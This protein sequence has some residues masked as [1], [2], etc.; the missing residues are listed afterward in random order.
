MIPFRL[1]LAASALALIGTLTSSAQQPYQVLDHWKIGGTGGWGYLLAAPS[2]HLL[3]ITPGP[4]VEILDTKT[5]KSVGVITGVKGTHGIAL[6]ADGK[7]GYI[8][9]GGGNSVLVFDRTDFHTIATIPTG[10]N[11]ARIALEPATK[12]VWA[13]NGRSNDASVI[14]T[15]TNKVVATIKLPGKPEFPVAD[16]TGTVFVNIETANSIS[17]LDAKTHKL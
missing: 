3:Y 12:T 15:A 4:R 5:G 10:T 8:S 13:C 16:G 6:D 9:D 1:I 14:D 11:P 7:F 17:K 2:A